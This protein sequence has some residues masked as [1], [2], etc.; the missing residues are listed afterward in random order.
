MPQGLK[1]AL[2]FGGRFEREVCIN[3]KGR[4]KT[5]DV[6]S[7]SFFSGRGGGGRSASYGRLRTTL[8]ALPKMESAAPGRST[9]KVERGQMRTGEDESSW[10]RPRKDG[11]GFERTAG[12]RE[13][14][15]AA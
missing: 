7:F 10:K 13:G 2:E 11:R 14:R 1:G 12:A 8:L 4:L 15:K 5:W 3:T 9:E 6:P